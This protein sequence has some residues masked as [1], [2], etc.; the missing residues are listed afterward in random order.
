MTINFHLL[1]I[2]HTIKYF[3]Q[4]TMKKRKKRSRRQFFV[5]LC[6]YFHHHSLFLSIRSLTNSRGEMNWM[7]LNGKLI[8][9]NNRH[10]SNQHILSWLL[11]GEFLSYSH[12]LHPSIIT[13][14]LKNRNISP[15]FICSQG[16]YYCEECIKDSL[17][18]LLLI[19]HIFFISIK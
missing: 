18:L 10:I 19:L 8:I 4:I 2:F 12:S 1:S 6:T 5:A 11:S 13:A 16:C 3:F 9:C 15:S 14:N 17:L 7:T